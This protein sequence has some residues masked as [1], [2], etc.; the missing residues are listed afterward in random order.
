MKKI[1]L[2]ILA[3]VLALA[4][5]SAATDE[6]INIQHSEEA[7]NTP[8]TEHVKT[9]EPTPSPT[10]APAEPKY[11]FIVIGDGLGRGAMTLG[12]IYSRI[13]SGDMDK[14]AVWEEFTYQSYVKAMGESA[15]G[16]T[17]IA[18]GVETEPWHIGKDMDGQELYTI[19]DRAKEAGMGTGV[20]TNSALTDA[21]PATFMSHTTNRYAFA[22]IARNFSESNVDYIAGGGIINILAEN[23]SNLFDGEDSAHLTPSLEGPQEAIPQLIELGYETYIGLEGAQKM[24]E[25]LENGTYTPEKSIN[26]F[27]GGIMPYKYYKYNSQ[28]SDKYNDVPTIIEMTEAG[29]QTLS[30][31]D[32]GFVMMIEAALI[33]KSAHKQSQEMEIYEV[34]ELNDLLKSL[35]SFYNEHPYETLIIL[36]ADHE[37]G[38]Y[39]Y[40][41]ELLDQWKA[42]TD[43]VLADSGDS[44]AEF[45]DQEW[46]INA[47]SANLQTQINI[48]DSNPWNN[49]KENYALLYNALT[50]EVCQKY[51]TEIT[52]SDHSGQLVPLFAIGT[53]SGEFAQSTHIKEIP[54]VICEIMGWEALPEVIIPES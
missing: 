29:I 32:N 39:D 9:A 41:D 25:E 42:A 35:M 38:N 21:T 44:M 47:Y 36:T 33:D 1:I 4:S 20:I 11:I 46:G 13:E 6:Q 45:L 51:G 17:A 5:C 8:E 19:M 50:M 2:L 23:S 52:S 28:G 48:A 3:T 53:G 30:Q 18:S 24:R 40:N 49:E 22:K 15:S 14:G 43:F 31:N 37:T 34:S 54:I 12:E 10:Y 7:V 16:G 27:T 26:I